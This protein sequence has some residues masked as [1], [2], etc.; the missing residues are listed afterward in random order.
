MLTYSYGCENCGEFE[1]QQ[2]ISDPKLTSCPQCGGQVQRLISGGGGFFA[3]GGS[4]SYQ[5]EAC[6]VHDCG[7]RGAGCASCSK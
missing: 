1:H 4:S 6:H 7:Q 2:R 5:S 3:K